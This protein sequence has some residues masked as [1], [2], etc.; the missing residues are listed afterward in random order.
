MV[1]GVT[2]HRSTGTATRFASADDG[3]MVRIHRLGGTPEVKVH[4]GVAPDAAPAPEAP[5]PAD[6]SASIVATH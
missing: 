6:N 1:E 2:I 3:S 4:R 5:A